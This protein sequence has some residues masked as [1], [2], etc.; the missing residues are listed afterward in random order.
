MGLLLN[1][2]KSKSSFNFSNI[3]N[4]SEQLPSHVVCVFIKFYICVYE[5]SF[6][7]WQALR[8]TV[9]GS[10]PHLVAVVVVF[11]LFVVVAE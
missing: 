9:Y 2:L 10:M 1:F 3:C 7:R 6:L 4:V 5:F 11:P 8:A